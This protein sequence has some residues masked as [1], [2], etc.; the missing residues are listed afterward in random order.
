MPAKIAK[1]PAKVVLD[2]V[3]AFFRRMQQPNGEKSE[4]LHL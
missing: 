4:Q 2:L 1:L 3:Y